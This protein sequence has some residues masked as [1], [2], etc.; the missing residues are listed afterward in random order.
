MADNASH[1]SNN[2]VLTSNIESRTAN[3]TSRSSATWT[4]T[5]HRPD[6]L[7]ANRSRTGN[8]YSCR[9]S[10]RNA[11]LATSTDCGL[12]YASSAFTQS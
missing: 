12:G 3:K 4:G 11:Y 1:H 5:P 2:S 6:M 8:I 9:Q 10:F 7:D